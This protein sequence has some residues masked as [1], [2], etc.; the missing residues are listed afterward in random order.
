MDLKGTG[1]AIVTPFNEDKS[2]DFNSLGK[3]VDFHINNGINYIV[4]LGT[5]G[6]STTLSGEEKKEVTKFIV[7]K[8]NKRVPIVLGIGGNNTAAVVNSIKTTDLTGI[9][10]ILSVSPYYN[11]PSQEGIYQHYKEIALASPLDI[12]LYNVPGRT[13]S[14]ISAETT[15]RLAN[16]FK[17]IVATKEASGDFAQIMKIIKN[18]PENFKVLSGDDALALPMIY[19]G[20]EG[21]ISV[22]ANAF[23]KEYSSLINA[24]LN[25]DLKTANAYQYKLIDIIQ[26]LFEEGSPTGIKAVLEILGHSKNVV[27]LPVV[28]ATDNLYNKL[29]N[30]VNLI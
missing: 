5:T 23:P 3:I 7:D 21:V 12:V 29:K 13:S 14:N 19:L 18:K 16:D 11:K 2:I 20:G 10:A 22:V 26:A 25:Y 27:R 1:T 8:V 4:A 28:T 30:L 15:I 6:E 9:D 17:N 24:A